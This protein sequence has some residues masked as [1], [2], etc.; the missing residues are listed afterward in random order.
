MPNVKDNHATF[1]MKVLVLL[2]LGGRHQT[3]RPWAWVNQ[4]HLNWSMQNWNMSIIFRD[5]HVGFNLSAKDL[6]VY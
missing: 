2:M 6:G 3:K 1:S 4:E 5:N